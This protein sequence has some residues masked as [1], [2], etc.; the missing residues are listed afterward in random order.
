MTSQ[1]AFLRVPFPVQEEITMKKIIYLTMLFIYLTAVPTYAATWDLLKVPFKDIHEALI[2]QKYAI[3]RLELLASPDKKAL[4]GIYFWRME[5]YSRPDVGKGEIKYRLYLSFIDLR[6]KPWA[7]KDALLYTKVQWEPAITVTN[8]VWVNRGLATAEN[9]QN[10]KIADQVIIQA[11][12]LM[13]K[14]KLQVRT[15]PIHLQTAVV[16]Q[17]MR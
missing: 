1:A 3:D 15:V 8:P 5:V 17:D 14:N 9:P 13:Q 4:H 16:P 12:E 10:Q 2:V 6:K 11:N 7:I